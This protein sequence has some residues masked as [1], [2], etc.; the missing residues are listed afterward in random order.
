[1]IYTKLEWMG[2]RVVKKAWQYIQ[3]FWY[4]ASVWQMDRQ[5]DVQPI[6]ISDIKNALIDPMTL[7]FQPL[8][9]IISRISQGH[10]LYTSLSLFGSFVFEL[11]CRYWQTDK[12]TELNILSMPNDV[13]GVGNQT[14][15]HIYASMKIN[16]YLQYNMSKPNKLHI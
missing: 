2:Y 8:N 10:S 14:T 13:V 9:H 15:Q 1:L 4:S 7:I 11:G 3:P 6:S 5:T 12:L 16:K